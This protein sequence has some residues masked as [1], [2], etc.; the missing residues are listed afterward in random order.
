MGVL[1]FGI[2]HFIFFTAFGIKPVNFRLAFALVACAIPVF[3]LYIPSIS[4][5]VLKVMVPVYMSLLLTMLWRAVSRLQ[6]FNKNVEWTWTKLCC[7]LGT[8]LS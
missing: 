4:N 1:S 2:A 8:A 5:Y 6:I 7:S 3:A